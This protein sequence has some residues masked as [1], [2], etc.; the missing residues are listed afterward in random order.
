M[1]RSSTEPLILLSRSISFCC[2]LQLRHPDW[3]ADANAH[4]FGRDAGPFGAEFQLH[5]ALTGDI[6]PQDGM[7]VNLVEVKPQ[8]ARAI[9]EI[10]DKFLNEDIAHFSRQRPTTENIALFLWHSLPDSIGNGNL[11]RLR[12]DQSR[13]LSVEILVDPLDPLKHIMKASR[14][15]EFAAAHRLFTPDLSE[16]ENWRRFDKCSNRAGHGH[17]FQLRV[18]VEGQ[19][20]AETGFIINPRLLDNI[21]DEEIYQR[22]DHKHL[23]DDCLEFSGVV[24]TS[25]N[26][27]MVIF[28]LL[29]PRIEREGCKLAR[30]GLRETQ[31]NYFEVEA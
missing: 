14:S 20:D 5:V 23:N 29:K 18:W 13:G 26:L 8:L 31:K 12:L 7:I 30:I 22:F 24:P 27:A 9:S 16:A 6:S 11:Y 15:Y 10:E 21:V 28:R 17:N 2:G 19:P 25:E 1:P 4:V 3:S